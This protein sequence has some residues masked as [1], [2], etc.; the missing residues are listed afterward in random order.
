VGEAAS[1]P[2]SYLQETARDQPS[3]EG[4]VVKV[5]TVADLKLYLEHIP[6]HTAI[7]IYSGGYESEE[8][9]AYTVYEGAEECWGGYAGSG[10]DLYVLRQA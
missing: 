5:L 8:D 1:V 7:R 4:E 2:L 3:K 6:D 9:W 10:E